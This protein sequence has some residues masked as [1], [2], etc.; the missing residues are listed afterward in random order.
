MKIGKW[1]LGGMF[2]K[3][4]GSVMAFSKKNAPTIMTGGSLALGW[5]GV[6]LFWKQSRKADLAIKHKEEEIRES[7]CAEGDELAHPE[8]IKLDRKE[9]VIIYLQYCWM[10]LLVGVASS[11]LA[12]G[13]HK[14][15]L[16][17]LAQMYMLTQ[18]LEDKNADQAKLIDKLKEEVGEKK[19]RAVDEKVFEEKYPEKDIGNGYIESTGKGTTLFICDFGGVKFRSS[20]QD[21]KDGI[22]EF[23]DKVKSRRDNIVKKKLRGAFFVSEDPYPDMDIYASEDVDVFLECIGSKQRIDGGDLLEFRDY[24]QE[25]FMDVN[26]IMDYKKYTDPET[27]IPAVCFLRFRDFLR[28]TNELL[29]R[30]PR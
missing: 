6:W 7:L 3:A 10:S 19:F 14:M 9:K 13:A 11:G 5:F 28:P 18:F 22:Y 4:A 15:D 21:V 8:D 12:I 2:E 20:I 25:D 23:R 16:S 24:G 30:D 27:G 1:D 29:E 26:Q 17:R